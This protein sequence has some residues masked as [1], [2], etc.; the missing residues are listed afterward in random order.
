MDTDSKGLADPDW[1]LLIRIRNH[2]GQNCPQKKKKKRNFMLE[3]L[4]AG[5]E[6]SPVA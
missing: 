3:E 1:K 6:A 4:S 2:A 5:L